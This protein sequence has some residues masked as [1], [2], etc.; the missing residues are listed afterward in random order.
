MLP[1]KVSDLERI[2]SG[3]LRMQRSNTT[4]SAAATCCR[5][6][7]INSAANFAILRAGCFCRLWCSHLRSADSE[8][9]SESESESIMPPE[10]L[11]ARA[12]RL[13]A[14]I[15]E[16]ALSRGSETPN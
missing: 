2:R 5:E 4:R 7:S 16:I 3:R 15:N 14:K 10:F 9:A 8:F 1:E 12:G 13:K 6:E 11:R